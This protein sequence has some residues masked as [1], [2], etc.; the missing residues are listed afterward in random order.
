MFTSHYVSQAPLDRCGR[1]L[2]LLPRH[3]VPPRAAVGRGGHP[4][5]HHGGL[6]NVVPKGGNAK[7]DEG[8]P[9]QEDIRIHGERNIFYGG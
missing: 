7:E 8:G 9:G 6:R 1:L 4:V 3:P 5:G 2:R